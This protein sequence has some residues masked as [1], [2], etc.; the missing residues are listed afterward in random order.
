MKNAQTLALTLFAAIVLFSGCNREPVIYEYYD[1]VEP[2]PA[3]AAETT[4][5]TA[6]PEPGRPPGRA[7]V[8]VASNTNLNITTDAG[9]FLM[10]VGTNITLPEVLLTEFPQNDQA[11]IVNC[12]TGPTA[13]FATYSTLQETSD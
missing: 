8:S 9:E 12:L 4:S 13:I 7:S 11:R 1:D 3:P 2:P 6:Q 5:H 10:M